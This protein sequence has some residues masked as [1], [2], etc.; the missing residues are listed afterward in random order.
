MEAAAPQ[1]LLLAAHLLQ[2]GGQGPHL[3]Q[4]AGVRHLAQQGEDHGVE[5]GG[6]P[7]QPGLVLHGQGGQ[8]ASRLQEEL[9]CCCGN[10]K[11]ASFNFEY[12]QSVFAVLTIFE[13]NI[14]SSLKSAHHS[15]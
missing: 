7:V 6:L 9:R 2:P 8:A 14:E 11:L 4:Q 1:V 13:G 15:P 5:G 3:L 12:R 10:E